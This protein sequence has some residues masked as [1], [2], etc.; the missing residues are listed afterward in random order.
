MI[1]L[2]DW[3][4]FLSKQQYSDSKVIFKKAI[5]A[6]E[7]REYN[8]NLEYK[9][10]LEYKK[11]DRQVVTALINQKDLDLRDHERSWKSTDSW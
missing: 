1:T 7:Q 3:T 11:A 4:P 9:K 6:E 2:A 8:R 10:H 5:N